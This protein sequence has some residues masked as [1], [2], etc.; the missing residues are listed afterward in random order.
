VVK[1]AGFEATP[2]LFRPSG[3]CA[4]TF[5]SSSARS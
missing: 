5:A 1:V 4:K 2:S 3:R